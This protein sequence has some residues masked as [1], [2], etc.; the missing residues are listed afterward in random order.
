[1][2]GR[3]EAAWGSPACSGSKNPTTWKAVGEAGGCHRAA[4]Q[5]DLRRRTPYLLDADTTAAT[6]STP[7][8]R[9]R[10]RAPGLSCASISA[11]ETS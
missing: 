11:Q 7:R 8:A 4:D 10:S 2:T 1:M 3:F 5:P 6:G 9:E